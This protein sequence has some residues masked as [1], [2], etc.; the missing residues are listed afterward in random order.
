MTPSEISSL[1]ADAI[2]RRRVLE[3]FYEGSLRKVEPHLLGNNQTGTLTLS[4]WQLSGGSA[5]SWRA[6]HVA[7]MS[8][9]VV[10]DEMFDG[11]RSGYNPNDRTMVQI[12]CRI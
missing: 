6:F 3:F 2:G 10:T 4:A 9:V 8:Q 11:P 7:R 12:V 1:I 5:V